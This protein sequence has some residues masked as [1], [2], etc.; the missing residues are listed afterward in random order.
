M[1][2]KGNQTHGGQTIYFSNWIIY[3]TVKE[4]RGVAI[5]LDNFSNWIIYVTV[6]AFDLSKLLDVDFSNWI[7]YVTVKADC[8]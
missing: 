5:L 2:V 7:I 6:K 3:V 4:S 8:L 1:T